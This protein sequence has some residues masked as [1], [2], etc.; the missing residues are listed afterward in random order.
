[1]KLIDDALRVFLGDLVFLLGFDQEPSELI[2]RHDLI[3]G[4][5]LEQ[6]FDRLWRL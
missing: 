2:D 4:I 1:M 6:D 5:L 3:L